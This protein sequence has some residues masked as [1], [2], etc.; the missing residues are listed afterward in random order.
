MDTKLE[1]NSWASL[2]RVELS[3]SEIITEHEQTIDGSIDEVFSFFADPRYLPL[4]I[5][6]WITFRMVTP[7]P[8]K[9]A[10]GTHIDYAVRLHGIPFGWQSEITNWE[11]PHRFVDEQRKGPYRWWIHTHTFE[12]VD[13]GRTLVRDVVRY[14][15]PGGRLVDKLLVAPDLS[16]IFAHRRRQLQEIFPEKPS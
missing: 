1:Q 15:V 6:D 10:Q 2:W 13:G 16:R 7:G 9:M 3:V 12:A 14:G 8:V 5:P 4:L 11:P